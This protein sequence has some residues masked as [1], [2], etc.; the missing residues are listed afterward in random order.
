MSEPAKR[1]YVYPEF[2]HTVTEQHETDVAYVRADLVEVLI[3]ALQTANDL[4][5]LNGAVIQRIQMAL[6]A[7]KEEE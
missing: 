6:D 1:I 5:Q 3:N 7:L 2:T 4:V